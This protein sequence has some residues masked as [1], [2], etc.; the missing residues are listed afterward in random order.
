M[1]PDHKCHAVVFMRLRLKHRKKLSM[2]IS[3]KKKAHYRAL[4]AVTTDSHTKHVIHV[5]NKKREGY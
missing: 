5:L 3:S 4:D 1:P 2:S